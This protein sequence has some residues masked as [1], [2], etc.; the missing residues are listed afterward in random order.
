MDKINDPCE[1]TDMVIFP[2]PQILR[3]D[4]RFG[5]NRGRFRHHQTCASDCPAAQMH[6]MPVISEPIFAGILAQGRYCDPVRKRRI[7]NCKGC[8]ECG[9][10]V[11][12][13]MRSDLRVLKAV[14][15]KSHQ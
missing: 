4:S 11:Y 2:Y 5:Q 12:Q 3:T 6:K 1:I 7:A 9:R 10:H 13:M 14:R 8:K 15:T